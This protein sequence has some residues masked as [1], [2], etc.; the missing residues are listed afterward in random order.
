[1]RRTSLFF[2]PRPAT[3]HDDR[4]GRRRLSRPFAGSTTTVSIRQVS[5]LFSSPFDPDETA[6][7]LHASSLIRRGQGIEDKDQA[8]AKRAP[9]RRRDRSLAAKQK[10]LFQASEEEEEKNFQTFFLKIFN[11]IPPRALL[12]RAFHNFVHYVPLR[13]AAAATTTVREAA[14]TRARVGAAARAFIACL[15]FFLLLLRLLRE[16]GGKKL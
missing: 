6:A 12:P 11:S 13:G 7:A 15:F 8:S 4:G 14:A 9:R 16:R 5:S 2:P 1:M 3:N 10:K